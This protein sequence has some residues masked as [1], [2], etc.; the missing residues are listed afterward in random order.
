MLNVDDILGGLWIPGDG[1][2]DP[3]LLCMSLIRE[4][5]DNGKLIF[6][7]MLKMR[8][9]RWIGMMSVTSLYDVK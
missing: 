5:V 2:G 9:F 8:R 3:H 4:A 7:L 6:L 1:V